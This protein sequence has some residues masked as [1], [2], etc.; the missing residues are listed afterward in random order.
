[1]VEVAQSVDH[2]QCDA[3]IA[4][5]KL[6]GEETKCSIRRLYRS[7]SGHLQ[8]APSTRRGYSPHVVSLTAKLVLRYAANHIVEI[9]IGHV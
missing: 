7:S 8:N 5:I 9:D 3:S 4:R 2:F 6:A 1:M